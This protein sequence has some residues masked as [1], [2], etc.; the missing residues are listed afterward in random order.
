[1]SLFSDPPSLHLTLY[2][3]GSCSGLKRMVRFKVGEGL[4]MYRRRFGY[5]I[6]NADKKIA[7][8]LGDQAPLSLS[9]STHSPDLIHFQYRTI[10]LL[11][12]QPILLL[13]T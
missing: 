4:T 7:K 8:Q 13:H 2:I 3:P 11:T 10:N 12:C 1:M 6:V 9:F 5:G